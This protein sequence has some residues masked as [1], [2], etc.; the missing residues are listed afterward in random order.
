VFR[1]E[2]PT[3]TPAALLDGELLD[4]RTLLNPDALGAAIRS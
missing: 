2:D 1:E 4:F 3:G